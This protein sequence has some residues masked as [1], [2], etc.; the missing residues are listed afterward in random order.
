[1]FFKTTIGAFFSNAKPFG[2]QK[3]ESLFFR[4]YYLILTQYHL[5]LT[6]YQKYALKMY[7]EKLRKNDDF[8]LLNKSLEPYKLP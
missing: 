3:N 8:T 7:L 4:C 1:M 6:Q 5:I 2:R